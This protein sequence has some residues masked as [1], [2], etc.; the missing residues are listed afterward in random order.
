[1]KFGRNLPRNQVPEWS[2][3][4]IQYKALKKLIKSAVEEVKHGAGA[5]TAGQSSRENCT[6]SLHADPFQNSSTHST[7]TWKTWTNSTIRSMGMQTGGLNYFMIV[8]ASHLTLPMASTKMRR[9]IS[10]GLCWSYEG[11]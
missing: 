9:K 7:A 11:S 5:D 4:Y 6:H 10:W 8:T 1:M 3:S 2:T